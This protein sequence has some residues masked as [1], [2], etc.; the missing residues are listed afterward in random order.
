[1][2]RIISEIRKLERNCE[3]LDDYFDLLKDFKDPLVPINLSPCQRKS[4][5]LNLL[6]KVSSRELRHMTEIGTS[7]GGT[8]FLLCKA[9]SDNAT[10]ITI[11]TEMRRWRKKLLESYSRPGQR[12]AVIKGDS[13]RPEVVELVRKI[14]GNELDLLF[15][16]GDHSYEGVK[17]DFMTY[18]RLVRKGGWIAFHDIVP[19]YRTRYGFRTSVGTGEVPKF[20]GEVKRNYEHFEIVGSPSQDGFGI[21]VLVWR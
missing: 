6:S 21:G 11:D 10:I 9:A 3:T 15:I 18:S 19:D 2:N 14:A 1:M 20:W 5:F 13:H 16:D 8:F 12:A 17:K 4:E 7:F